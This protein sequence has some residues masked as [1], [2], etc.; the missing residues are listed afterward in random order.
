MVRLND[1]SSSPTKLV[2]SIDIGASATLKSTHN[3]KQNTESK[4]EDSLVEKRSTTTKRSFSEQKQLERKL[5]NL[6]KP[7]R[8]I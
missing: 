8:S 1:S 4:S 7:E 5:N 2:R 6:E 3:I